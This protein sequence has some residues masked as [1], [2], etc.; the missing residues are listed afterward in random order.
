MGTT[1]VSIKLDLWRRETRIRGRQEVLW[2]IHEIKSSPSAKALDW[3]KSQSKVVCHIP[4]GCS[5][6]WCS[7]LVEQKPGKNSK[8]LSVH[9]TWGSVMWKRIVGALPPTSGLLPFIFSL[10]TVFADH[11]IVLE[12]LSHQWASRMFISCEKQLWSKIV[13]QLSLCCHGDRKEG[14]KEDISGYQRR[15][16]PARDYYQR[17]VSYS[18]A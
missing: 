17:F 13:V 12:N 5:W 10:P 16:V 3:T 8:A 9:P 14:C 15:R 1:S 11:S 4:E 2:E 7:G 18:L 6:Q